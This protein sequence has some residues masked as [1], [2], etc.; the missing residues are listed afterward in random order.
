MFP[1][2]LDR[3]FPPVPIIALLNTFL[4]TTENYLLHIKRKNRVMLVYITVTS[5]DICCPIGCQSGHALGIVVQ[6]SSV[7][8]LKD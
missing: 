1:W 4:D 5:C 2:F 8:R 3:Y 7:N 6:G